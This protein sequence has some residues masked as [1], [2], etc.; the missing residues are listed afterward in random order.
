MCSGPAVRSTLAGTRLEIDVETKLGGNRHLATDWIERFAYQ[1]FIYEWP[2]GF[3][4][5]KVRHAKVVCGSDQ[6]DHLALVGSGAIGRAHAHAT[7]TEG[8]YLK[9]FT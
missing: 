4:G 7:E 6:H 5:I 9:I 3:S 8:R 2:V 1:L